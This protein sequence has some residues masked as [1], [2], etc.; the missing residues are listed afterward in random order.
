M[1]KPPAIL[2]PAIHRV[3]LD[4][5]TI[6]EITEAELDEAERGSSESLFLN[7]ALSTISIAMS[8]TVT[9]LT[10]KI[11]SNRV[12]IGFMVATMVSW[13]SGLICLT[14]WIRF[15]RSS[16]SVFKRIRARLPGE[17]IQERV[18]AS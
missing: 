7:F 9:L 13:M 8:L 2:D 5:L 12:F 15:K 11:D 18:G 6:F 16:T 14:I 17:G 4:R 10:T 3:R 1:P